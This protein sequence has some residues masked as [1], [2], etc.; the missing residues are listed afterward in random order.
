MPSFGD[1]LAAGALACGLATWIFPPLRIALS[2]RKRSS[3]AAV[4]F[5]IGVFVVTAYLS[6]AGLLLALLAFVFAE[7]TRLAWFGLFAVVAFW[8]SIV[9]AM[10]YSDVRR[11]RRQPKETGER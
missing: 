8:L 1:V 10:I 6:A 7:H 2:R 5:T 3:L 11:W 4:G 9:M